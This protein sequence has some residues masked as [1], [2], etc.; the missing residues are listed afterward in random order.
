MKIL[1]HHHALVYQSEGRLLLPSFIGA[2]ID[3]IAAEV[4]QVGLLLSITD[5]L[6]PNLDYEIQAKNIQFHALGH[7]A[8]KRMQSS[9]ADLV[10]IVKEAT[11]DYDWL[12]IRGMTP[13]QFL[14]YKNSMAK[15]AAFLLV[16]SIIDSK[17]KFAFNKL[18][19]FLWLRYYEKRFQLKRMSKKAK[20]LANSP[21]I[22]SELDE[23]LGIKASFAPTNTLSDNQFT[24][25]RP[26]KKEG[27]YTMVFCG[28]IVVDKGVE[29]LIAAF[30]L[31]REEGF[32]LK[33]KMIGKA[34]DSYQQHL[35]NIIASKK[36]KEH[37]SFK[38][39]VKFGPAL[40]QQYA[41]SDLF[42]LPTW[43]EGFPH[44]IWE[45]AA[46]SLPIFVTPVGGIPGLLNQ[47][48]VNFC[49]LRNPEDLALKIKEALQS[50]EATNVRTKKMIEFSKGFS[51]QRCANKLLAQI[52][53]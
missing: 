31:L 46:N 18:S 8:G 51:V 47:E 41:T 23:V 21:H 53:K 33:L 20:I 30:H 17:P 39:F 26:I 10:R 5:E 6:F 42:V 4:D 29:E 49:E 45:A 19:A 43:H 34:S 24:D 9:S 36:L 15:K 2:W 37:I 12:L 28:R 38:G 14:V 22:V 40:M 32:D 25:F 52:Q 11:S 3:A 50:N 27:P 16:G 44:S 7:T 35:D 13:R 1:I 48:L